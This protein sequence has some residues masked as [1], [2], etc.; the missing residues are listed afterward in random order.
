MKNKLLLDLLVYL[1]S[2]ILVFIF[3]NEAK[4][5][6]F[7]TALVF[8]IILYTMMVKRKEGRLNFTGLAFSA[9]CVIFFSLK[10]KLE[11]G[12]E[13]YVYNT[14]FLI[15]AA[16]LIQALSLM[17]RNV[18]KQ[19][20]IDILKCKGWSDLNIWNILKKSEYLYYFNKMSSIV[21]IHV[22]AMALVRVYTMFTY[23]AKGYTSTTD[24]EILI[25]VLFIVA[26]LYLVSKISNKPKKE[27]NG[28]NKSNSQKN[29]VANNKRVINLNQYKNM[30]K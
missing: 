10:Q 3:L 9:L 29:K 15:A 1:V 19:A 18:F 22:L 5:Q 30:N 25:C 11:P 8:G 21:S 26:E 2:P 28:Q 27:E 20:Y 16:M 6:L 13:M 12:Y 14:Y 4:I 17:N 24:L 23:G 7:I